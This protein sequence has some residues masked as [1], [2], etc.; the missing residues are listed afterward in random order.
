MMQME[1]YCKEKW[2]PE[3][4]DLKIRIKLYVFGKDA[5]CK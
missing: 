2:K 4:L 1:K 5:E 3:K